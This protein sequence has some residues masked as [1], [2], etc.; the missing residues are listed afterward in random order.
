MAHAL[1]GLGSNLGDRQQLLGDAVDRLA[2]MPGV[3][4]VR[5]S[6]WRETTPIGG[7]PGQPRFFNGAA[8]AVV[9]IS[10]QEL[11]SRMQEI[12]IELGRTR[13][14]PWAPRTVDLDLLLYDDLVIA[15]PSLKIPHPRMSFRKFVIEPAAEI[16]GAMVHPIIGWTMQQ[17][18]EHVRIALPYVAISGDTPE[19]ARQLTAAVAEPIDWKFL[20]LT[21]E[22]AAIIGGNS[23]SLTPATAI[24][25]LRNAAESLSR[26]KWS[27]EHRGVI[28]SF[29][30]EDLKAAA[31]RLAPNMIDA[32]LSSAI[33]DVAPP[34]LL[35]RFESRGG[36]H[37]SLAQFRGIGPVLELSD[38][39]PAAAQAE[40]IAAIQAMS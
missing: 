22:F 27:G 38:D 39:D 13:L 26:D 33:D 31:N 1:L 8:L 21:G 34:K 28:S 9:S 3:Q 24:E 12:E 2:A 29:W 17:L 14:E 25:F 11:F 10:P 5:V 35:V 4:S 18:S 32:E 37:L 36:R 30:I 7:P 19:T 16:A 15:S 40:L 23:A 6:Q 20:D